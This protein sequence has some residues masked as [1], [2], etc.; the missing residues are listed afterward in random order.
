VTS[1]SDGRFA[2]SPSGR[3][4]IGN[5]RTALLAWLF[6]RSGGGRFLLRIEDLDRGRSRP[7]HERSQIEDLRAIG[8]DWDGEPLRQSAR[9]ERYREAL[10]SLRRDG[11]VYPCWC[12][13]AEIRMAAEA[14]HGPLPEGAYPGTCRR[15]SS[16]ERTERERSGRPAA[17][18]LDARAAAVE[19][20][21]R[22]HGLV[23][24][25]VDDFVLWRGDGTP[26][27]Q[28]AVVVDDADQAVSEVVRGDDLLDSTPR[29][30]QI[31]RLLGLPEPRYA[32]V[33]LVLG[34]DGAR[35]AKRHGAVTLEGHAPEAAL[36]WMASSLRMAEPGERVT[37]AELLE[38][39]DPPS[40]PR[41]PTTLLPSE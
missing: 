31:A 10:E 14:P 11:R 5:L 15:L 33:P 28:L 2:P 29:Q 27:Y 22:L 4:H 34:P 32:H 6:A 26:A 38:R 40:L 3:L 24:G 39:F 18:R 1:P 41:Q 8:L 21:D 23:S 19:F 7:E 16:T 9:T 13:R 17:L 30:I 12:T 35:L 25:V 37:P 36:S 20:E